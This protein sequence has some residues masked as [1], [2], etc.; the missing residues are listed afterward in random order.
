MSSR[1]LFR[2]GD[3]LLIEHGEETYTLRRTRQGKLLLTK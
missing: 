3:V 1:A 2:G